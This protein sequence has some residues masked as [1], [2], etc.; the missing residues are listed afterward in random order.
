MDK[1]NNLYFAPFHTVNLFM[2]G[3]L[4]RYW[5]QIA[6]ICCTDMSLEVAVM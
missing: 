1:L 4:D 5:S 3:R 6:E 2:F